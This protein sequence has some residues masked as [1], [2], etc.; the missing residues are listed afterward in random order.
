MIIDLILAPIRIFATTVLN[1]VNV[2]DFVVPL[3]GIEAANLFAKALMFFPPEVYLVTMGN[4][5]FWTTLLLSW[6][7]IEWIYK[8]IPG[9]N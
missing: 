4:I 8:K 9:I 1:M 6:S 7:L 2:S 5:A 3:W